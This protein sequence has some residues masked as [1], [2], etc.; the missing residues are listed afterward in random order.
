LFIKIVKYTKIYIILNIILLV[1]KLLRRI[2]F[3][4]AKI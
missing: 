4:A 2:L 1:P 3:I